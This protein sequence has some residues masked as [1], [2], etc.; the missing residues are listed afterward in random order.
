MRDP[1]N[2]DSEQFRPPQ[3]WWEGDTESCPDPEWFLEY[4]EGTLSSALQEECTKKLADDLELAKR[5]QA[6]LRVQEGMKQLRAFEGMDSLRV[7]ILA[8]VEKETGG[9]VSSEEPEGSSARVLALVA[10]LSIAAAALLFFFVLLKKDG[11]LGRPEEIGKA[12]SW[13]NS[14]RDRTRIPELGNYVE[15][16]L[17]RDEASKAKG[18]GKTGATGELSRTSKTQGKVG[19]GDER[20]VKGRVNATRREELDALKVAK[21]SRSKTQKAPYGGAY[22]GPDKTNSKDKKNLSIALV[23]VPQKKRVGESPPRE[24]DSKE[25]KSRRLGLVGRKSDAKKGPNEPSLELPSSKAKNK[26]KN[27]AENLLAKGGM[28]LPK[29][30]LLEFDFSGTKKKEGREAAILRLFS[31]PSQRSLKERKGKRQALEN[32][33]KEPKARGDGKASAKERVFRV[34]LTQAELVT[35][36]KRMKA[37]GGSMREMQVPFSKGLDDLAKARLKWVEQTKRPAEAPSG[38]PGPVTPSPRDKSQ[39]KPGRKPNREGDRKKRRQGSKT[40]RGVP[41]SSPGLNKAKPKKAVPQKGK[42]LKKGKEEERRVFYIRI[43]FKK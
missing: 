8:G 4:S 18:Y 35:L 6:Y 39:A 25:G 3:E 14:P 32:T 34:A 42:E 36:V 12:A 40:M 5:Y 9:R 33:S 16:E 2:F 38:S 22:R 29:L 31:N 43:R 24:L 19:F 17:E 21:R 37:L 11:T 23:K 20:V 26:A 30:T 27:K 10:S 28:D 15:E 41:P 7:R 1:Q 13:K